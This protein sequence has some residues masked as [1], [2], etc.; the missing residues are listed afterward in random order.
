MCPR[1][2]RFPTIVHI[3]V[4]SR[5][6]HRLACLTS[7]R[8][9][10]NPWLG[11]LLR[12]TAY[13]CSPLLLSRPVSLRTRLDRKEGSSLFRSTFNALRFCGF[14]VLVVRPPCLSRVWQ[15]SGT[16]IFRCWRMQSPLADPPIHVVADSFGRNLRTLPHFPELNQ[17]TLGTLI[18]PDPSAAAW[19]THS[20][21]RRGVFRASERASPTF[22][23]HFSHG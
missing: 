18:G 21:G 9:R 13:S 16:P 12:A 5:F 23:Q 3:W 17:F 1:C 11:S 7:P 15:H 8:I 20:S 14:D 4:A 10:F 6:A 22:C 19:R 2:V